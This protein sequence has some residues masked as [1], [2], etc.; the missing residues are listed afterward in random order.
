MSTAGS[1]SSIYQF[2][3]RYPVLPAIVLVG[4]AIMAIFAPILAP[5]DPLDS[6]LSKVKA[7]PA[8]IDGGTFQYFL[9][10]DGIGRD[11]LSRIIFGSRISMMVAGVVILTGGIVGV[12]LGLVAGYYGGVRDEVI[13]RLVDVFY[14]IPFI[15]VALVVA[16]VFGSSLGLVMILLSLFSWPIF[17]RQTRALT[18]QLKTKDY[19]AAAKI[20]GASPSRIALRHIVPGLMNVVIVIATLQVGNLILTESVLSFLGI[21]IPAPQPAWGSMIAEGRVFITSAWWIP[22]MPGAA[23]FLTVFAFNFLGDWLRDYYDP[24]L[25]QL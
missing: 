24:N 2:V 11:L 16:V 12:F 7:P 4:L 23:V 8:W 25:R 13:M 20:A 21:G 22:L 6:D 5:L 14:A 15:L 17:A 1:W 3:R 9:G 10:A 18:L 19:V